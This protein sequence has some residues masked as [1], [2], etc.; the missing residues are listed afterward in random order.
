MQLFFSLRSMAQ[1]QADFE[2][3]SVY[4]NVQRIGTIEVSSL[5]HD[6]TAYLP[7][8]DIFDFLKIVNS[9]SATRD[10]IS[11]FFINQPDTYLIDKTHNLIRYKDKIYNLKPEDL[12]KTPTSLYLN[13]EYLGKIFGLYCTFS[14]RNLS[15]LLNTSLELPIMREMRQAEMRNNLSHLKGEVKVDSTIRRTYPAFHLGM[16]DWSVVNTQDKQL[17]SDTRVVLGLGGIVAGGETNVSINY[18]STQ[19]LQERDQ[20]YLWRFA[21]NDNPVFKQILAGKIFGQATSSI[22]API[23]GMQVTNAPTTYRRSFGTYTL[24]NTTQ[25]NWIVELYV[26]NTLISYVRSDASGYYT[27]EVPLVYGSSLVKL[28]FYGPAGEERTSEQNISVP[29][30]FLPKDEFEYTASAGIVEDGMRSRYSRLSA[31]YGL[32]RTLTIGGGTEYLSSVTSGT[33]MPFINSSA[34][35]FSNLL[36][37]GEYTYGVRT[38]GILTYRMPSGIQFELNDTWYKQGQ[39]AINNT[40]T[41]ERKAIIS[42]P[43]RGKIFSGY[44]RITLDQITLPTTKYTTTEWLVSGVIWNLN[45]NINTY[46]LFAEQTSPYVYTTFSVA[47]IVLK[48]LRFTQQVQYEYSSG[49]FIGF[50][51]EIESRVFKKGYLNLSYEKIVASHIENIELG[52][53]YDFSFAQTSAS[54]R[55]TNDNYRFLQSASGSLIY[56]HPTKYLGLTNHTSVGKGGITII[57]YLDLNYNGQ[58]DPGEP[59]AEGLK[60]Q[61]YGG[62][63]EQN[64]RDTTI[65]ITDLEPYVNYILQ[66]DPTSFDNISWQLLKHNFSIAIDPNKIKIVEIPVTVVAEASG[67]VNIKSNKELKGQGRI[68]INFYKKNE[69][70]VAFRTISE[71]DGYFSYLG[72]TPGDYT[73][74][75][76]T[77]QLIKLNL[78][79]IPEILNFNV[80]K[81][82][83]GAVVDGLD[84][85]LAANDTTL[86]NQKESTHSLPKNVPVNEE[87]NIPLA[88]EKPEE[89]PQPEFDITLQVAH[90]S[91][92]KAKAAQDYLV[93]EFNYTVVIKP[94][95]HQHYN[96]IVTG[97]DDIQAAKNIVRKIKHKGFPDAFIFARRRPPLKEIPEKV[98]PT[99]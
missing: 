55:K 13:S 20:Y 5:I 39:N 43:F 44:T 93:A 94:S 78:K 17:G 95:T 88:K 84:F 21:N 45:A 10:S 87:K 18:H 79:S 6:Q 62:R 16:A 29:F 38:K 59:R 75:I 69:N 71:G 15:V 33:T 81:S 51:E 89:K 48:N 85:S 68:I 40:F 83:E 31:N 60:L 8:S 61:S 12:I 24:S 77:A 47:A 9:P 82:R 54:V 52:I 74:R 7:V 34:R 28:K 65:R 1:S 2:E 97:V 32:T 36:L 63:I 19:P 72:L 42:A 11:G 57:P 80:K 25:P 27:F 49:K 41:E 91:Y 4:L 50:K 86:K 99:Q 37:S 3:V 76:D 56:D 58:R 46:A 30:N 90:L 35:L 64:T 92:H 98:L 14:F 67:R 26:N 73:V 70:K 66:L 96:V 22:Y 53:R 23:V